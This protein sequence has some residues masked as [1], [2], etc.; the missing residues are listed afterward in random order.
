M[1]R[2]LRTYTLNV[3][4][5]PDDDDMWHAYC[6]TLL[7]YGAATWGATREEAL[8]HIREVMGMIVERIAEGERRSRSP[9]PTRGRRSENESSSRFVL[10]SRTPPS[11]VS[12]ARAEGNGEMRRRAGPSAGYP[13]R[14]GQA[15]ARWWGC[16]PCVQGGIGLRPIIV[17]PHRAP[18]D[19]N[20]SSTF[21]PWPDIVSEFAEQRKCCLKLAITHIFPRWIN[22]LAAFPARSA[23]LC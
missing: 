4:V 16:S 14:G 11:E 1:S 10:R 7:A 23:L 13:P 20:V 5:E 6:P 2:E 9:L 19:Q 17:L 18:P 21:R 12:C 22:A 8:D 3:V 15:G